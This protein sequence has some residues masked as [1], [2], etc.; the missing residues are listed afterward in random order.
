MS[1]PH[2]IEGNFWL[3]S[4]GMVLWWSAFL[5]REFTLVSGCYRSC[6][7]YLLQWPA[8]SKMLLADMVSFECGRRGSFS[9][10]LVNKICCHVLYHTFFL[11]WI[12]SSHAF[13]FLRYT[14]I[15]HMIARHILTCNRTLN[16]SDIKT[17]WQ[18]SLFC[19]NVKGP[20]RQE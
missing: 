16:L 14:P 7:N 2:K 3:L 11:L 6:I 9:I 15:H 18:D 17:L 20:Q 10:F 1:P 5:N 12:L 13:C 19:W 8:F 4:L